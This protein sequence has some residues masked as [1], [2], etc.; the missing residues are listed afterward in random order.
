MLAAGLHAFA[1][2][3]WVAPLA[4]AGLGLLGPHRLKAA[5][6]IPLL[7]WTI[8]WT[9]D[10]PAIAPTGDADARVLTANLLMVNPD[11]GP[12]LAELVA[13]DPDVM[14]LQEVS[15]AWGAT[16]RTDPSLSP[17][18][19]RTIVPQD[20][21]FGIAVLSK[22]PVVVQVEDLLGVP[23]ARVE[24]Q[25]GGQHVHLYNVHTLPPRSDAYAATWHAQ[26]GVL[27]NRAHSSD[28]PVILAGDFNATRH[29]PSFKRL[30]AA[31]LRDAHHE[32]GRGSAKTWPNGLFPVPSMGL[33]H[34]LVGEGIQVLHVHEAPAHGSDH[35]PVIVDLAGPGVAAG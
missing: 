16:L 34:V 4:L 22:E 15:H 24:L 25:L 28:V 7:A 29:H 14:V 35:N 8:A 3:A 27:A 33:D 10:G 23:M 31:G 12:L 19:H 26:M 11:H 20:G 1:G 2:A 18:P 6:A 9:T 30:L 5:A 13:Q 17:W 21:S 32:V